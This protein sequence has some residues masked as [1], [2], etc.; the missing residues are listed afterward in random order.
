M[1]HEGHTTYMTDELGP[2]PFCPGCGHDPLIRALDGALVRLQPDPAKTVIV[3]DIGCIGLSDRYFKTSAFHG[4]HGRSITYACGLKLARP[5]LSVIVLKGDGGCGIGGTHLL[6]VARRNIGITLIVANNFN[7]GMTG[8]QHSVTTPEGGLTSTTP[9]GNQEMPMDL[10]ATAAAAGAAWVW[11]ASGFDKDL[12]ETL[13]NAISQP[14]F[15]MVDCWEICTAY[16]MPRNDLRKKQ[17]FQFAADHGFEFGLFVDKPRPEY[18]QRYRESVEAARLAAANSKASTKGRPPLEAKLGNNLKRQTGIIVAG[19]AGQKIKSAATTFGEAAI[20]ASLNATQKDDYPITVKTGHSVAEIIVSPDPIEYT[21]IASPDYVLLISADG[22]KRIRS[23][24]ETLSE[25][26][27][28][29]ADEAIELPETRAQV[30]RFP[31]VELGK[32]VG[33][34]S[35]VTAAMATLL[36][37]SGIFPLDALLTAI[38]RGHNEK[39]VEVNTKAA[40]AGAGLAKGLGATSC[41]CGGLA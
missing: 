13:A 5:D 8:G 35:L 12:S 37:D 29:Y 24:V 21:G 18:T 20:V 34:L 40:E 3:T 17:L 22:L 36:A 31:F 2:L 6:N 19:S 30:K 11:R 26:C 7:Y 14:G 28:I 23:K 39:V 16:Y 10:C 25:R 41:T 9:W 32:K 1:S 15:S 38:G 27:V 33:G 4:L